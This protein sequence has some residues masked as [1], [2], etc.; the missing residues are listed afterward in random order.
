MTGGAVAVIFHR[1]GRAFDYLEEAL[2]VVCLAS[3]TIMNFINVVSRYCFSNSF[4]FTEEITIMLFVWVSM[5]GIA[6]GFKRAA[7]LGMNY[8]VEKFPPRAQVWL[9]AFSV[10]CSI[11]MIAVMIDEGIEMVEGQIMLDAKTPA[12]SLPLAAQ[13]LAIPVGGALIAVRVLTSGWA[14]CSRLLAKAKAQGV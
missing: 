3:M 9:A 8:F 6:A 1:L 10:L 7:H 4:S 12:L 5:F 2:I 14:E 11:T 13:G